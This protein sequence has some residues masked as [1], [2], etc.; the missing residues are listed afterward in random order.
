[1][2]SKHYFEMFWQVERDKTFTSCM[3]IDFYIPVTITYSEF[4]KRYTDKPGKNF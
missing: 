4:C 3:N 1:M 2:E